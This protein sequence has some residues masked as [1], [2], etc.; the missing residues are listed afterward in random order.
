MLSILFIVGLIWLFAGLGFLLHFI[1]LRVSPLPLVFYVAGIAGFL[2]LNE[3]APIVI[4]EIDGVTLIVTADVFIPVVLALILVV[5]ASNGTR[6]AQLLVIGIVSVGVVSMTMLAALALLVAVVNDDALHGT[7]ADGNVATLDTLRRIMVGRFAFIADMLMI[8]IAY[9]GIYNAWPR[10]RGGL[11]VGGALLIALWTDAITY[12]LLAELGTGDFYEQ[13][14]TDLLVKGFA[15]LTLWPPTAYYLTV[16]V[17][18][19]TPLSPD[20]S[21]DRPT[22]DMLNDPFQNIGDLLRRTQIELAES[23]SI[24]KKLTEHIGDIF[25][26]ADPAVTPPITYVSP[27]FA[28]IFGIEHEL[29]LQTPAALLERIHPDD[30]ERFRDGLYAYFMEHPTDEFRI[31][32][33][34]GRERWVRSRVFPID[35][36]ASAMSRYGGLIEDITETRAAEDRKL[37]LALERERVKLLQNFIRDSSHDLR[38]PISAILM[39]AHLLRKVSDPAMQEKYLNE[40]VERSEYLTRLIDNLFTLSRIESSAPE[41]VQR[42]QVNQVLKGVCESIRPRVEQ[43]NLTLDLML[44]ADVPPIFGNPFDLERAIS[45]LAE[46]ALRYTEQGEITIR[47]VLDDNGIYVSVTDSG[48]G[49]DADELERIF[50]R[51]FRARTAVGRRV[52]GTG[53]GLAIVKS[54]V[55]QHGGTIAVESQPGVGTTFTLILPLV[56][57]A[58]MH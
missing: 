40:L 44:D 9:Q 57:L 30:R 23:R 37:N 38:T 33:P 16:I 55:D 18:Q 28:R 17:P 34:D 6:L 27:S 25:W 20:A 45:N 48:I 1:S 32:H 35:N 12:N 43:K 54:V 51:F 29:A 13:L 49:I 3:I 19:H 58:H 36:G 5:Y 46:N 21:P 47:S 50:D 56:G 4:E 14:G 52:Q 41:T 42:I 39:R 7:L 22:L 2:D 24:Y 26:L 53:L 10:V 31:I 15:A 11:R 8:A